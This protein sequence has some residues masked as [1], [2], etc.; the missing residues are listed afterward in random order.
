[1]SRPSHRIPTTTG[2]TLFAVTCNW[3]V[4]RFAAKL[5]F[6][7]WQL[8]IDSLPWTCPSFASYCTYICICAIR[9]RDVW[10]LHV[11]CDVLPLTD[12]LFLSSFSTDIHDSHLKRDFGK[13]VKGCVVQLQMLANQ[14][15]QSLRVHFQSVPKNRA[16]KKRFYDYWLLVI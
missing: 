5:P 8:V 16:T 11:Q 15:R 12:V 9:R 1:M 3:L 2:S 10:L 7:D 4:S 6:R 14:E 13:A